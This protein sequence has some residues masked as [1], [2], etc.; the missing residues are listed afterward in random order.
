GAAHVRSG[1]GAQTIQN[2]KRLSAGELNLF[3]GACHRK[4]PEAGEETDWSNAWN[5]RHE[6]DY[7]SH[8]ACF[9]KSNGAL[10]CLTCHEPHAPVNESAA[11]YDKR[12][13]T[14]HQMVKHRTAVAGRACVGCHMPQ[15]S[16][17][18]QLRFTHHW[19]GLYENNR[20]RV[21]VRRGVK[22]LLPLRLAVAT[23]SRVPSPAEP[24]S[25][26]PLF[27]QALADR[28]KES[29]PKDPKVARAASDLG[30]F[31]RS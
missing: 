13:G 7:L 16:V 14:C 5:I 19:I 28:E 15:G 27:E 26:T 31:L 2:P 9:R 4:P 24:A 23:P 10:S 3:C 29:G 8:A 25:L 11:A 20:N 22:G 12:C 30:M 18:P 17:T 6:P 1:G 21:P